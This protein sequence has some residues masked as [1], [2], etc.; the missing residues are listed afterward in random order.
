MKY[1]LLTIADKDLT[2]T[3]EAEAKGGFEFLTILEKITPSASSDFVGW[4]VLLRTSSEPKVSF[5][6]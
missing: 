5:K 1:K 4:R 3:L 2:K 6:K